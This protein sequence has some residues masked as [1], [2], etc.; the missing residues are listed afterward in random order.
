MSLSARVPSTAGGRLMNSNL[1]T[2]YRRLLELQDQLSSGKQ[3]RNP[4][5]NPAGAILAMNTRTQLRRSQ[6]FERNT[7][8]AQAWLN[9]ADS[10]LVTSQD[11]LNKIRDLSI[12]A[13]S[14]GVDDKARNV[15][16]TQIE[17]L[18]DSLVQ[19]GNTSY[20]SRP[21]FA[22]TGTGTMALQPSGQPTGA[23]NTAA[24]NRAV[25][26][27]VSVQINTDTTAL[28][29][30][31]VGTPGGDYA[32]STFEVITKLAADIRNP[33]APGADVAA[34]QVAL[35]TARERMASVQ[36]SLGA[37]SRRLED[38]S[39][40]NA[41]VSLELTTSLAEVEDID[42][43]KTIIDVQTQQMAYQ[44]ALSVTAKV[45]Q[46]SLVDFLR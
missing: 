22:G 17:Q 34:G 28:Y 35:D 3:I 2:S 21:I 16:A 18:R 39:S 13:R 27:G 9:T 30:T 46:P 8:D 7:A 25:A 15:I 6:Q 38:V 29:G 19:L 26:P 10:A 31:W 45:I 33:S 40:R 36:A 42:L 24:V 44:A 41:N 4:S 20:N 43:P 5:D 23:A 14:G 12:Q 37:R 11:Y 32:G 1:Q